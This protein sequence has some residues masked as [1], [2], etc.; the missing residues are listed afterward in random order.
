[1]S[2]I[3][4]TRHD[5]VS[6]KF[7]SLH[8]SH[9][10]SDITAVVQPMAPVRSQPIPRDPSICPTDDEAIIPKAGGSKRLDK[11]SLEYIVKSGLAGGIAGCAV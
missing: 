2:A 6:S 3:S 11:Q 9:A 10:V 4:G 7:A 1:M 5:T 8:T